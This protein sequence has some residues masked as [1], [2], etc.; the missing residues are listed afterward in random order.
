MPQTP[1]AARKLSVRSTTGHRGVSRH[2]C[3]KFSVTVTLNGT[4]KYLGLYE[5]LEEAAAVAAAAYAGN[6]P[7][8]E[9]K[10]VFPTDDPHRRENPLSQ[11]Q[12]LRLRRLAGGIR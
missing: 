9:S 3:G 6:P 8:R 12:L 11:D 7:V 10:P 4:K 5:S 2:S 1:S